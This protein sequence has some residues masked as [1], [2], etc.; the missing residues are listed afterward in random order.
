MRRKTSK[1][2]CR[3][4]RRL[5]WK[6]K[7]A[8][9][10]RL[11]P[12]ITSIPLY[13][14]LNLSALMHALKRKENTREIKWR[15]STYTNLKHRKNQKLLLKTKT[16]CA[17]GLCRSI[18]RRKTLPEDETG[19]RV[20]NRRVAPYYCRGSAR[21]AA[22][23]RQSQGLRSLVFVILFLW[24]RGASRYIQFLVISSAYSSDMRRSLRSM[25]LLDNPWLGLQVM[26]D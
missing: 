1:K 11:S 14:S 15:A 22:D 9:L 16:A 5:H 23:T 7:E 3:W 20:E 24:L 6:R 19:P 2:S 8:P 17:L 12:S 26:R 10:Y 4:W 21:I 13:L 18:Y 25:N